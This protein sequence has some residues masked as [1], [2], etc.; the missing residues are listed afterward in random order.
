MLTKD[1]FVAR[2]MQKGYTKRDAAVVV[3]DFLLTLREILVNGEAVRFHGFGSFEVRDRVAREVAN[4]Q[5]GEPLTV[6]AYRAPKFT[7]GK[8]L[9]REIKEGR[10]RE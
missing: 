6:P 7:A 4:P 8:L 3:D 2:F 1:D 10:I 5:T 9:K